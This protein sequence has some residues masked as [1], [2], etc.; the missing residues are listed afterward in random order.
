[1]F[2]TYQA[3]LQY[4]IR[5]KY[6]FKSNNKNSLNLKDNNYYLFVIGDYSQNY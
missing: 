1:M 4:N 6:N 5:V 3:Q 2:K